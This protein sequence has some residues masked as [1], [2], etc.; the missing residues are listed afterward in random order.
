MRYHA[1]R[2]SRRAAFTLLELLVVL[3]IISVLM[4]LLAAAVFRTLGSQQAGA[5]DTTLEK[6]ASE[7]NKQWKVVIQQADKEG[8]P[9]NVINNLAGGDEKRAR[10]IW[11]KLRLKQEF[12]TTY[13]EALNP[14]PG[15]LAPKN[16]FFKAI[17]NPPA[18]ANDR[19]TE[20]SACL[21]IALTEA[22]GGMTWN[23]ETTL[24]AGA[25]R[26]TD[27]DGLREIV[28]SWAKA[29]YFVRV[30]IPNANPNLP[31]N[32]N[33]LWAQDLNPTTG[34]LPVGMKTGSNDA[35]DPDGLLINQ[36]WVNGFG[37]AFAT[38]GHP[39]R[40]NASWQNLSPFVASAGP[41]RKIGDNDD[42]FS[43]R[44]KSAGSGG[45]R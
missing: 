41:N 37:N 45:Q 10:V 12:P 7:L 14:A 24:G 40:N 31:T 17:K 11:V 13:A 27:S 5:T 39:V 15:Y 19:T 26:D 20:S 38:V 1:C 30:P 34:I 36:T 42:R 43:Y 4:A 8:I 6:V 23:P 29:I 25:I 3:G 18:A 35:Q 44:L 28:D 22:R 33:P 9:P 32:G 21:L 16:A 2:P